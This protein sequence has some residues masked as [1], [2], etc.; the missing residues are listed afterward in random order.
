MYFP[1]SGSKSDKSVG[2][3]VLPRL[4]FATQDKKSAKKILPGTY[5]NK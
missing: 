3:E 4:I 1:Q 5:S 2:L